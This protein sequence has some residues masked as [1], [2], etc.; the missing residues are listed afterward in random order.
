MKGYVKYICV[1]IGLLSASAAHVSGSDMDGVVTCK[2]QP[3]SGGY[4][5]YVTIQNNEAP[6]TQVYVGGLDFRLTGGMTN[7]AAP[8]HWTSETDLFLGAYWWVTRGG[9]DY[10]LG[11]PPSSS[12]SGFEFTSTKLRTQVE[13]T[14][15]G[16]TPE[17]YSLGFWGIAYP[18]LVP[19]PSA[20]MALAGGLGALGLPMMRRR[21]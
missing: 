12:L 1:F 9:E 8:P 18:Q 7:M 11:V 2:Y 14:G 16:Y 17:H 19:E 13:Y 5:Y 10:E 3:V 21:K 6:A 20:L 15:F 4:R